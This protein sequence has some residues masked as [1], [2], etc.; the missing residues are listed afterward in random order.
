MEKVD[1]PE[2]GSSAHKDGFIL[3]GYRHH[4]WVLSTTLLRKISFVG[5]LSF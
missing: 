4:P 2:A 5:M 1:V 3:A